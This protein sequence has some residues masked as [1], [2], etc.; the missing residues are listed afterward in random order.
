[1]SYLYF[2][3]RFEEVTSDVR[4]IFFWNF[5]HLLLVFPCLFWLWWRCFREQVVRDMLVAASALCVC[6]L[7][8]LLVQLMV[9][10][11]RSV[12]A[13]VRAAHSA[14]IREGWW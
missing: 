11:R 12:G 5:F 7:V 2:Y 1:L 8:A 14:I 3:P 4:S 13:A 10:H 9:G 6:V